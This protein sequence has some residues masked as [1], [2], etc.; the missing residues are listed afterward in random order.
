MRRVP[1]V[2]CMRARTLSVICMCECARACIQ[3]SAHVAY[4][5]NS[6]HIHTHTYK[7]TPASP[8]QVLMEHNSTSARNSAER[9]N[10]QDSQT[11][12][13]KTGEKQKDPQCVCIICTHIQACPSEQASLLNYTPPPSPAHPCAGQRARIVRSWPTCDQRLYKTRLLSK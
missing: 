8:Q 5:N 12:L 9:R 6:T 7:I 11:H 1:K 10:Q 2:L 3:P 13:V 4:T